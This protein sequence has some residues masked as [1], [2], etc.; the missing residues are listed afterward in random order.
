MQQSYQ[1]PRCGVSVPF[2][3]RF[4]GNCGTQLNWQQQTQITPAKQRGVGQWIR[5]HKFWASVIIL[6][7]LVE[8]LSLFNLINAYEAGYT[9]GVYTAIG[10]LIWSIQAKRKGL[11]MITVGSFLAGAAILYSVILITG[12]FADIEEFAIGIAVV[13]TFL[14]V[15]LILFGLRR[16]RRAATD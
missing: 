12:G 8:V 1:C 14:S 7:V 16:Y 2:G 15:L 11:T 3:Y 4:C 6:F 10:G 9:G 13:F 5:N